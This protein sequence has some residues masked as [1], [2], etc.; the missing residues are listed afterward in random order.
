MKKFRLPGYNLSTKRKKVAVQSPSRFANVEFDGLFYEISDHWE[1]K[2]LRLQ[3]RR[4]R[5]LKNMTS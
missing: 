1:Q 2:A 5:S 3:A 4:W